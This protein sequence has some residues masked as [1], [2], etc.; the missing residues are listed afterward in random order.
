MAQSLLSD[1]DLDLTDEFS[2]R[3]YAPFYG[4]DLA[5]HASPNTPAGRLYSMHSPGLPALLLPAYALDG[6]RGARV[7]ASALAAVTGLLLYRLVHDVVRDQRV[8]ATAWALATFT[9]PLAFYAVTL[10]PETLAALATVA[11]L[12]TGRATPGTVAAVGATLLAVVLPW[13]HTKFI[14]LAGA[15]LGP[16]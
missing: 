7:F 6:Y 3:E 12:L 4:G 14:P 8:A 9:P 15:G 5:P 13:V 16:W 10:Y 1:G 2:G 11:F